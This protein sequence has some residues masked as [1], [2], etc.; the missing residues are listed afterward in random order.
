MMM[1]IMIVIIHIKCTAMKS[2]NQ[3][4]DE[5]AWELENKLIFYRKSKNI[6]H[7][8]YLKNC[9]MIKPIIKFYIFKHTDTKTEL[10]AFN[11]MR[12]TNYY[13]YYKLH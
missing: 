8:R 13:K 9:F 3:V 5:K 11:S 6:E 4:V 10:Y 7:Q 12:D 1:M 2:L